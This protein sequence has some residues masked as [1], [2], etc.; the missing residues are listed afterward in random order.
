MSGFKL[1]THT[2]HD[3]VISNEHALVQ[4]NSQTLVLFRSES[5]IVAKV[6]VDQHKLAI[7]KELTHQRWIVKFVSEGE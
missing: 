1:S 5:T 2:Q 6:E 3:I 7:V 4:P